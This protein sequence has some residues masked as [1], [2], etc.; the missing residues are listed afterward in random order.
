MSITMETVGEIHPIDHSASIKK[1]WIRSLCISWENIQDFIKSKS[2]KLY[3][4]L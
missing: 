4:I 3:I 1:E 2:Y